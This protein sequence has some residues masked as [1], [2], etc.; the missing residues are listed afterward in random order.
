MRRIKFLLDHKQLQQWVEIKVIGRASDKHW[1]AGEINKFSISL[2]LFS[3]LNKNKYHYSNM[4]K[5]SSPWPPRRMVRGQSM[6]S[7]ITSTF[8]LTDSV[9]SKVQSMINSKALVL[10]AWEA[11]GTK[12]YWEGSFAAL[13]YGT[14]Q[15]LS[16]I[17][18]LLRSCSVFQYFCNA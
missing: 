4:P 8:Y 5:Q 14:W 3:R 16:N 9:D 1:T 15:H 2:N 17:T 10:F 11:F 6:I 12:T 7:W 18:S 13:W